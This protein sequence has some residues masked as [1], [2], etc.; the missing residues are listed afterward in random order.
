MGTVAVCKQQI[1]KSQDSNSVQMFPVSNQALDSCRL[2]K[3]SQYQRRSIHWTFPLLIYL[4]WFD[5]WQKGLNTN[6][7]ERRI[8]IKRWWPSI[9]LCPLKRKPAEASS[10]ADSWQSC[11]SP[12]RAVCE[13]DGFIYPI[14]QPVT[15]NQL[16]AGELVVSR[17][18]RT[19][20]E[21]KT[22]WEMCPEN[23][24][25][26]GSDLRG[27]PGCLLFVVLHQDGEDGQ[28]AVICSRQWLVKLC[29]QREQVRAGMT[30]RKLAVCRQVHYTI[31]SKGKSQC[32]GFSLIH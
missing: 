11:S 27:L 14:Q 12:W 1:N 21:S 16:W 17:T 2:H 3:S 7:Y 18:D 10:A 20:V 13:W 31:P 23:H 19:C 30:L 6:A 29:V 8:R 26:Y 9:V 5:P 32:A 4:T 28:S 25:S 22:E 24:R 15:E